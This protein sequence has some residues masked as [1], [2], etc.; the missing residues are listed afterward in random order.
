M[1]QERQRVSLAAAKLGHQVE[2]RRGFGA[3]TSQSPQHL[4]AKC[5]QCLCEVGALEKFSRA[6][7]DRCGAP[8]ANLVEMNG[9]L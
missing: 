9:K 6:R 7:I 3:L 1:V 5:H 8:I 2:D 4:A